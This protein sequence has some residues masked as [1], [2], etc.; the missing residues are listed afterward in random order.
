MA[1]NENDIGLV[2]YDEFDSH[3]KNSDTN[4]Q[5]VTS[6]EK[7]AWN[8]KADDTSLTEHKNAAVLDHPDESVTT[9]KLADE[10]VTT[11]KIADGAV[12]MEKVADGTISEEKFDSALSAAFTGK[13]DRESKGQAN[14]YA[15]L[16]ATGKLP[17]EYLNESFV[18]NARPY[19]ENTIPTSGELSLNTIYDI[20][21]Q[22][23]NEITLVL[24][25]G[26]V[27]NFIQVDFITENIMPSLI[28]SAAS[29]ALL[30]DYDFTPEPNMIYSLFFDYG[31][32]GY[33]IVGSDTAAST[34]YGWRFSFAEYTYTPNGSEG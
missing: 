29:S 13:E 24:P 16:D 19:V 5:H 4:I 28:I 33:G 3:Q 11:E 23:N 15:P 32:L 1:V 6:D 12:T 10:G 31:I 18:K 25:R 17:D 22:S 9:S 20:G 21:I 2:L 14:G 27:G 8:A 30:S 26:N 34:I 7:T